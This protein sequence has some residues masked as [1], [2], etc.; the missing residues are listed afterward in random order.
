[1]K[2]RVRRQ[3]MDCYSLEVLKALI[4]TLEWGGG[5]PWENC[6]SGQSQTKVASRQVLPMVDRRVNF[7]FYEDLCSHLYMYMFESRAFRP[8]WAQSFYI[9]YS[10]Q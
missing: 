5:R 7:K 2:K 10:T 1:M 8:V 9:V 4:I 3:L 6:S